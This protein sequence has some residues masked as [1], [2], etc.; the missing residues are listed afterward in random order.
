MTRVR[1]RAF[2]KVSFIQFWVTGHLAAPLQ[3]PDFLVPTAPGAEVG[4]AF[5]VEHSLF[6]A[7]HSAFAEQPDFSAPTAPGAACLVSEQV[8]LVAQQSDLVAPTAP[9]AAVFWVLAHPAKR[10]T[11]RAARV[12]IVFM[13]SSF[14]E[15]L[16]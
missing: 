1:S 4:A 3:Q 16:S 11:E 2:M 5:I 13:V 10:A 14:I 15:S 9:G 6:V 8:D 7:E 12:A